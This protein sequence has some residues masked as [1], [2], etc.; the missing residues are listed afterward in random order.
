MTMLPDD[1]AAGD[2]LRVG[3]VDVLWDAHPVIEDHLA[4]PRDPDPELVDA[5]A[6]LKLAVVRGQP[7]F[8]AGDAVDRAGALV[9]RLEA[10]HDE[11]L[12]ARATEV[13]V[14]DGEVELGLTG[15][16]P[17]AVFVLGVEAEVG[18]AAQAR[19]GRVRARRDVD[20]AAAGDEARR[21]VVDDYPDLRRAAAAGVVADRDVDRVDAGARVRVR[22]AARLRR[23]VHGGIRDGPV[24]PVDRAG[25]RLAGVGIRERRREVHV[26]RPL[27]L[28]WRRRMPAQTNV[29]LG[30]VRN[31][32]SGNS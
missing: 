9:L 4:V 5:A 18:A 16:R 28:P 31:Y 32:D 3:N 30:W 21:R 7:E 24:V 8:V 1:A 15:R 12:V 20:P 26:R 6:A 27:R 22:L 19:V 11:P 29:Q 17:A 25:V 2:R 23:L 14:P 13:E 10:R